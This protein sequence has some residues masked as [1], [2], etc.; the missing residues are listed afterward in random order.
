MNE[1]VIDFCLFTNLPTNVISKFLIISLY[2]HASVR[3]L[4]LVIQNLVISFH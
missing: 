4:W 3:A 2:L 1:C